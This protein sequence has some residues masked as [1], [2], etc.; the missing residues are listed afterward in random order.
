MLVFRFLKEGNAVANDISIYVEGGYLRIVCQIPVTSSMDDMAAFIEELRFQML[1]SEHNAN[2]KT[3]AYAPKELNE[4]DAARYIGRSLSYLR[5]FRLKG[6]G[7]RLENGPK[8]TRD[9]A[10][11]VRYPVKELDKWLANRKMYASSCEELR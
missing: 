9:T 8:Y 1:G 7:K 11:C 10:R 5:S 2:V 3:I 6:K 4:K